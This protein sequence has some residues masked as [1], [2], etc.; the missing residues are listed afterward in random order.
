MREAM[1]ESCKKGGT[2]FFRWSFAAVVLLLTGCGPGQGSVTI[3]SE[4]EGAKIVLNGQSRGVTPAT[5]EA[6]QPGQYVLE[7]SQEGYD[8][9]YKNLALLDKQTLDVEMKLQPTTGLLLVDS[10]PQGVEVEIDGVSKGK[11]PLLLSELPLGSYK[12]DF[13]S[14]TH[15]PLTMEAQLVDRKPVLVRAE[16]TSN[17]AKLVVDS[18]PAGADV[19]VNGVVKGTTPITLED[20]VAGSADIKVTKVGYTSYSRRM[21]VEATRTY[22]IKAELEALPSSLAVVTD[23]AGAEV[24]VDGDLAGTTPFTGNIKDGSHQVE[25]ALMGYDTV[26]TNLT[27]QPNESA[28][29]DFSLVK[30]S[31]VLVLDTEPADV[32]VFINGELYGVTESQGD[33]DTMSKPLSILLKAGEEY[34]VQLVREGYVSSNFTVATELD[35]LVTRHEALRR[36]FVRDTMIITKTDVIK[37]RLEYKLPNGNVYFERFPGVYDTARAA[38]IVEVKPIGIDDESNRDARRLLELNRLAVPSGK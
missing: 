17:T 33:M 7:L 20:I 6:L 26:T 10:V 38:D 29:M 18:E 27:L 30:N 8:V 24:S 25:V 4:P 36:I 1:K 19:L 5:L 13:K 34:H 21:D 12:F 3:D 11:T 35:Q 31:G 16:L 9:A 22:Q 15:L 14:P 32:K 37:C 2:V 23:P 28:R